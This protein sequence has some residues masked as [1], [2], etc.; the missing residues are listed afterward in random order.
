MQYDVAQDSKEKGNII[1]IINENSLN[2]KFNHTQ[3]GNISG[4]KLV[5]QK[6]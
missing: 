3:P 2:V 5:T 4:S 6:T 1:K